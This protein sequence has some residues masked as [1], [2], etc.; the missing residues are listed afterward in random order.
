[1]ETTSKIEGAKKVSELSVKFNVNYIFELSDSL[2]LAGGGKEEDGYIS[3]IRIN[4]G[5]LEEIKSVKF[6]FQ[7]VNHINR[8]SSLVITICAGNKINL[9]NLY[10]E[11]LEMINMISFGGDKEVVYQIIELSSGMC[12][13]CH[14]KHIVFWRYEDYMLNVLKS[15]KTDEECYQIYE[16][17]PSTLVAC[18][19]GK[20]EIKFYDTSGDYSEKKCIENFDSCRFMQEITLLNESKYLVVSSVEN[21]LLINP[22]ALEVIQCFYTREFISALVS[23][24]SKTDTFICAICTGDFNYKIHL[25]EIHFNGETFEKISHK[26]LEENDNMIWC[27]QILRNRKIVLGEQGGLIRVLS[28]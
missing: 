15:I 10:G 23:V 24:P 3:L 4:E 6:D 16:I 7:E 22:E 19:P 17:N 25:S 14:D 28:Y 12:V 11:D 18:F 20:K 27:I 5:K 26:E 9:F 1:M 13:S 2:L 8:F 21:L